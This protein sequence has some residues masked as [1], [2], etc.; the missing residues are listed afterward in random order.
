MLQNSIKLVEYDNI[1]VFK[2][3]TQTQDDSVDN[4][5]ETWQTTEHMKLE[6]INVELYKKKK[7]HTTEGLNAC[8]L[9]SLANLG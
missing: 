8:T 2:R 5:I 6:D 4:C 7:K 9:I 1:K 3:R